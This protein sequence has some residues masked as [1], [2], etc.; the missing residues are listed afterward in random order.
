MRHSKKT[1]CYPTIATE[2]CNFD[3]LHTSTLE[4]D[5]DDTPVLAGQTFVTSCKFHIAIFHDFHTNKSSSRNI[6]KTYSK[7]SARRMNS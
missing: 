3:L 2:L 7:K 6:K 4:L 5:D 1:T